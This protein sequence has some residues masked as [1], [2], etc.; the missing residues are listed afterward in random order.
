MPQTR[1]VVVEPLDRDGFQPFGQIIGELATPP[2]FQTPSV[3]VWQMD[4]SSQGAVEV[5]FVRYRKEAYEFATIERHYDIA[6]TFFPMGNS[7]SIMVVAPPDNENRSKIPEPDAVR[8]FFVDGKTGIVLWP[9][10]W[11]ALTRFPVREDGG[12]FAMITGRDTQR[13]LEREK[14]DGTPAKLTQVVDYV[15]S[16]GVTFT[17]VDP[18]GLLR[19]S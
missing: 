1:E 13:D 12:E 2:I 8:A 11:H 9:G 16:F 19:S 5:M 18:N 3:E 14:K 15:K 6:Q 10:T 7:P 4:F 17:L